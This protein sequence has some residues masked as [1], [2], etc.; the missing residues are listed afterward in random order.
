[1]QNPNYCIPVGLTQLQQDLI[2]IL[3]STHAR[4]LLQ[5]CNNEDVKKLED[6]ESSR[7]LTLPA[8]SPQQLTS[9]LSTN[10]RAVANHPC[11][12]VEH[13]MPRQLLLMEPGERLICGSDKFQKM[14]T[15]L[16]SFLSRDRKRFPKPLQVTILSHSVKE[17]DLI[18][19]YLLGKAVKLKRLSGASLFDEKHNY[20]EPDTGS[21]TPVLPTGYIKDDYE[22]GRRRRR[23]KEIDHRDWLFLA[24]ATHLARSPELMDDF[25]IDL[26]IGF[27][28]LIDENLECFLRMRKSGKMVPLIKLLVK[29]SPDHFC[30]VHNQTKSEDDHFLSS[31]LHFVRHRQTITKTDSTGWLSQ[32]AESLLEEKTPDATSLPL[33]DLSDQHSNVNLLEAVT[34]YQSLSPLSTMD[35]KLV[36]INQDLDIKTYQ[37]VLMDRIVQRLNSCDEEYATRE[38]D[39]LENR[40]RETMRQNEFDLLHEEAASIFK[41]SKEEEGPAINSLK[42]FNKAQAD[43]N[44]VSERL[45]VLSER[46]E[47]L[48]KRLNDSKTLPSSQIDGLSSEL[49]K[50][51][52]MRDASKQENEQKSDTND[53]LRAKYQSESSNAAN[54][55]IAIQRLRQNRDQLKARLSGPVVSLHFKNALEQEAILKE[56][57][58]RVV[59]QSQFTQGYVKRIQ[60]QYSLNGTQHLKANTQTSRSRR[61]RNA[62]MG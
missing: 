62:N 56:E 2:E 52:S 30:L 33:C 44:K 7:K 24:T 59:R 29:D 9:L 1:M 26:V 28:P 12:L 21:N 13:Y 57:L 20:G 3:I 38:K 34:K 14:A 4:S 5:F 18:E 32:F 35:F 10:I 50:L 60:K 25:S 42:K 58:I 54:K 37:N 23:T 31:L 6:L 46:K 45:K 36:P 39:I 49:K 43:Y 16:D 53:K 22:Y 47:S 19:G 61:Q 15:L 51:K 11:L 41:Q 40:L 17:L 8:L 27:D 48:S 55:S